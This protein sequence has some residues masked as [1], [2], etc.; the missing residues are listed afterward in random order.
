MKV[1]VLERG[2]GKRMCNTDSDK[3]VRDH[4]QDAPG[5]SD[6]WKSNVSYFLDSLRDDLSFF[7]HWAPL[8]QRIVES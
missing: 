8:E 4:K 7:K 2:W 5:S 6:Y 1:L 3:E